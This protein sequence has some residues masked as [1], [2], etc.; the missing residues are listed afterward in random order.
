MLLGTAIPLYFALRHGATERHVRIVG[1]LLQLAGIGTVALGVRATRRMFNKPSYAEL[2]RTW[3]AAFPKWRRDAV[4]AVRGVAAGTSAGKAR[5][6][7]WTTP[8]PSDSVERQLEIITSNVATLR[9]DVNRIEGELDRVTAD[10]NAAL[11]DE[12][13]QRAKADV[14]LDEKLASAQTGGLHISV[15]GLVWL[16]LGVIFTSIPSEI[17]ALR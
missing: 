17:V 16:A 4:I 14:A 5:A 10:H 11:S 15:V 1:M 9:G 6:T 8:R 7:V 12:A 2:L 13:S 3:L